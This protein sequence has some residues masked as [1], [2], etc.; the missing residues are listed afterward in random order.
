MARTVEEII[1]VLSKIN[2]M[3]ASQIWES[4]INR[5]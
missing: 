5:M 4:A 3:W 2:L 1:G